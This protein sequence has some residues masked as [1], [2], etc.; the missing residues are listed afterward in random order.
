M[1]GLRL[2]NKETGEIFEVVSSYHYGGDMIS[3]LVW[4]AVES[5]T[6]NERLIYIHR[7]KANEEVWE[8]VEDGEGFWNV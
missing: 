4:N 3:N 5:V 8:K 2:K 7:G 1:I 6:G